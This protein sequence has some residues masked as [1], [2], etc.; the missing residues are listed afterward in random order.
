M[1]GLTSAFRLQQAGYDVQVLE[2]S[3]RPGGRCTTTRRDGFIIDTGPE[4][5]AESY[6]NYLRLAN[7]VGLAGQVVLSSPVLG[8]IRN[9][10]VI[11]CDTSRPLS[12]IFTPLLSWK[13]KL[14]LLFGLRKI[15]GLLKQL[16]AYSMADNHQ[17]DDSSVSSERKA[18]ELFGDEV[19][20][21]LVDPL[22]RMIGGT[23]P[24]RISQ[25]LMLGGLSSW[26]AG[27]CNI[28]GG[29]DLL[30]RAVARQLNIVYGAR[31]N[32]VE[33]TENGIRLKYMSDG[34]TETVVAAD[35]CVLACQ[36]DD[37]EQ[38]APSFA[39]YDQPAFSKVKFCRLID[40]KLAYAM[41]TKSRA[42]AC[43][44]PSRENRELLMCV[45]THNKSPD[46][47]PAGQS[48]FTLYTDDLVFDEMKCKS[49][50][51][52]VAWGRSQIES[53]FPEVG[54]H[55]QFGHVSRYDRAGYLAEPGYFKRV[56]AI[57]DAIPVDCRIQL[58][59]DFFGA[60]SMEAAVLWGER[61]AGRV[62][63]AD[64]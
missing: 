40:I 17:Y 29:L 39:A 57:I 61:A 24:D 56:A 34:E 18:R 7:D 25:L 8:A 58:G 20:D 19:A 33:E 43:L 12:M 63:A 62:I 21:Y 48:L 44:V 30:P 16:D 13:A 1:S 37:L 55:F 51:D 38:I 42:C 26:S 45:L 6:S 64:F 54:G 31:V 50:E 46:R 9:G 27:L 28:R 60:G 35:R 4:I 36:V 2:A 23:R 22:V 15:R 3:D 11:E 52:L 10:A 41:N 5:A 59:G 49:D 47:A 32:S 14:K 53:L